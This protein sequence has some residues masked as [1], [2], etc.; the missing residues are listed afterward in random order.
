MAVLFTTNKPNDLLAAIKK[1]IDDG[2]IDTW[3]YDND[4]DF[5]HK[6]DQWKGKAW[7]RP[8]PQQGVLAFGLLG[9]K[10]VVMSKQIYGLFH[11]RFIDMMLTHFDKEFSMAQ[12]TAMGTDLDSFDT[13]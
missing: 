9:Q 11:G 7:L 12:A 10:E 4:G 8:R 2:K 3:I 1:K 13:K 5:T 6:P